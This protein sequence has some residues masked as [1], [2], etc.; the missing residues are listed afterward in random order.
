MN[1]IA[2]LAHPGEVIQ[3]NRDD[4]CNYCRERPAVYFLEKDQWCGECDV[5]QEPDD[6]DDAAENEFDRQKDEGKIEEES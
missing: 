3:D 6:L 4:L 1:F 2:D 5:P